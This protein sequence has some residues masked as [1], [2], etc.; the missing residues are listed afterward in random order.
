MLV[1]FEGIGKVKIREK[2]FSLIELA[3]CITVHKSQG[4]SSKI[5][6][7]AFPFHFLLNS[8]QIIYT[9]IT[10]TRKHCVVISIKKTIV[11]AIMKDDVSNKR[12]YLADYLKG[13]EEQY[14]EELAKIS[15]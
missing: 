12:T 4:S 14:K 9:A 7:I 1:D 6:I 10:R 11:K 13:L 2:N 8:R 15:A 5:I 3:Y